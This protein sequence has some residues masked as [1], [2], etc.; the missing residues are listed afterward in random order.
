MNLETIKLWGVMTMKR[1]IISSVLAL[2]MF[3]ACLTG[4]SRLAAQEPKADLPRAED[5][6]TKEEQAV[7]G[8]EVHQKVKTVIMKGTITVNDTKVAFGLYHAAVDKH[9]KEFSVE[10]LGTK[11]IVVNGDLAWG[12]DSITG[13]QILTGDDKAQ[14]YRDAAQ[15][16]EV[17]RRVG[18]WR[19]E[20]KEV[21]CIGGEKVAGK[22]AY[23]VH[24]TAPNGQVLIDYYDKESSL[25]VKRD[26][27]VD[28]KTVSYTLH[29]DFRKVDG[30]VHAFTTKI[31]NGPSEV[32]VTIDRI[33]HN[34][35]LPEERFAVPAEI[36][37]LMEKQI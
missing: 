13:A 12:T 2:G 25:L 18:N 15:F 1:F 36:K 17:F 7:G 34:V 9:Y 21:K 11:E 30:I 6:L 27:V 10:G 32:V 19:K 35:E 28:G 24:L 8:M 22:L 29:S 4:G 3:A 5:I 37:K 20:F 14:A 33:E 16:A 26:T 31:V 23:K